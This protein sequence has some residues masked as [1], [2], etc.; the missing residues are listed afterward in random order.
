MK[1]VYIV[2]VGRLLGYSNFEYE[3]LLLE[4]HCTKMIYAE[5][6]LLSGGLSANCATGIIKINF[7]NAE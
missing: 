2:T 4:G 1:V 3:C 7:R 6:V 5:A